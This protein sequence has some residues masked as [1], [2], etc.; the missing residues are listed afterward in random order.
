MNGHTKTAN[1]L[2]L[3]MLLLA[4]LVVLSASALA[5]VP[6][7]ETG[8][9]LAAY[10]QEPFDDPAYDEDGNTVLDAVELEELVGPIAL[11]PDDLL[12][13]ILPAS[14]YPLEIVQ[15][16]RFLDALEDDSSLEPDEE[17]DD[18]VIALLN[19]PEVV[20][21]LDENIDW[22]WKLGEA[23]LAQQDALIAAVESFRDRA[24]AAG[25]LKTD[26]H[27]EVT[28]ENGS[29]EIVPVDDE[30]IY[31]PYYEPTEVVVAQPRRVYYYYPDPY[32]VYYYPYPSSYR[33]RTGFFW[34]VTTAYTIGWS[35]RYLHVYH[36]SYWGH[37]YYGRYYY[38]HYYRRPS[39]TVYN[40]W[41]VD[42]YN[43]SNRYRYRDG[44]RWRHRRRAGTSVVNNY[45]YSPNGS[46]NSRDYTVSRRDRFRVEDRSTGGSRRDPS[47]AAINS[48]RDSRSERNRTSASRERSAIEFR[49]RRTS[50][51]S[52]NTERR[53]ADRRT[54]NSRSTIGRTTPSRTT[55]GRTNNSDARRSREDAR[56]SFSF[57]ERSGEAASNRSVTRRPDTTNRQRASAASSRPSVQRSQV[58]RPTPT[59]RE[60]SSA[61]PSRSSAQT[62]RVTRPPRASAPSRPRVQAPAASRPPAAP[63]ANTR[64][65]S[66]G[67]SQ[68]APERRSSNRRNRPNN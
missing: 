10:P 30:I 29:I 25:N 14:T 63:R 11:Y 3:E 62:S 33:F 54:T 34:G 56:A 65:S 48:S 4:S 52:V 41:Y 60:R 53:S 2:T 57:R 55:P 13:I 24:Y 17:W 42:H 50:P 28:Y 47:R 45:H 40:T 49:D 68:R 8:K 1:H 15:A 61:T 64:S 44:D 35:N 23:V 27:Q 5:Q 31:V 58:T 36:P 16:A 46:R 43:R 51:A 6:V 20:R 67:E 39:I 66:R 22:T 21:M 12:A 19:Y 59:N 32:P 18:A 9:P 7:D 26:E 38:G 37:P